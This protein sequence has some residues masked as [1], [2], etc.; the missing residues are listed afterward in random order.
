MLYPLVLGGASIIASII[1]AMFVRG[2]RQAGNIMGAL[3]K[4]VIVI[5]GAGGDR[6]LPDH[7][8]ML[9]GDNADTARST[10]SVRADRPGLTGLIVWITE[11]YTGTQYKPGAARR[12]GVDHRPRHQ[13]HRRPRRVDEVDRAAGDRGLLA[14]WVRLPARRGLSA[15][16]SPRPRCCRWPA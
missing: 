3:Y 13:H 4:G 9:M 5:G 6:V 1:G 8:R 7:H 11:Y 14:I 15:S 12:E 10:C 2:R 16:P